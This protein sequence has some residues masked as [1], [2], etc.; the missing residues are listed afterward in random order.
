MSRRAPPPARSTPAAKGNSAP[1]E[2]GAGA[3]W[4]EDLRQPPRV[5][6]LAERDHERVAGSQLPPLP[7]QA[8]R[9]AFP[10]EERE[11]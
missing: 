8:Q 10:L 4:R 7:P 6:G 1:G 11:R 5:E 3:G 9:A 2:E